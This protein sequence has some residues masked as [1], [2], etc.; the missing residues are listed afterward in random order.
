MKNINK[1]LIIG[2]MSILSLNA[3]SAPLNST[4]SHSEQIQHKIIQ[5]KEIL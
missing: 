4:M 1:F 2:M 3:I 5:M